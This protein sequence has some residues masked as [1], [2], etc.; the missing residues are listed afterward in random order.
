MRTRCRFAAQQRALISF[1]PVER[2]E[3]LTND[4]LFSTAALSHTA[5]LSPAYVSL[6]NRTC[7]RS[8]SRAKKGVYDEVGS[9]VLTGMMVATGRRV[10][11]D[12]RRNKKI[13]INE[14]VSVSARVWGTPPRLPEIYIHIYIARVFQRRWIEWIGWKRKTI[15]RLIFFIEILTELK[16]GF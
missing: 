7:P 9:G 13:A 10:A 6:S 15:S 3:S 11:W 14:H 12:K 16:L 4:V 5:Y 1:Q 8:S 2:S